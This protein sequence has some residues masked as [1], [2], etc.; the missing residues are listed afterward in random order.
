MTFDAPACPERSRARPS[1]GNIDRDILQSGWLLG[2]QAIA[3]KAAAVTVK[4]GAGVQR[5]AEWTGL[6][7]NEDDAAEVR[8]EGAR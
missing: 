3:K 5:I 2:E 6:A 1:S 7:G 8:K 4:Q